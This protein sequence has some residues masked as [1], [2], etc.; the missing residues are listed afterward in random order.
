MCLT[1]STISGPWGVTGELELLSSHDGTGRTTAWRAPECGL[2]FQL[3][4]SCS[5]GLP[6]GGI[7][8]AISCS[9]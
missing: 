8:A 3:D 1:H 9:L 5:G 6:W 7:S 4:G 2:T